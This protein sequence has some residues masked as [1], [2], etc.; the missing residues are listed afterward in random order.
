MVSQEAV[1]PHGVNVAVVAI[2]N[3]SVER[4]YRIWQTVH[5]RHLNNIDTEQRLGATV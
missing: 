2:P 1:F 3:R 4:V 5:N